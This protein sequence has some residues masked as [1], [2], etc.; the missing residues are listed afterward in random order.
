MRELAERQV[1]EGAATGRSCERCLLPGQGE[2]LM[3]VLFSLS[4]TNRPPFNDLSSRSVGKK[5]FAN[6]VD[7]LNSSTLI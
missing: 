4:I 6:G 2:E 3:D 7:S 1:G 5:S